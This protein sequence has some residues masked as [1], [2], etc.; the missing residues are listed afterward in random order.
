MHIGLGKSL[1][2]LPLTGEL[3]IRIFKENFFIIYLPK[4]QSEK[5]DCITRRHLIP[6]IS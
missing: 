3:G 2:G 1:V 6:S 4:V 5:P